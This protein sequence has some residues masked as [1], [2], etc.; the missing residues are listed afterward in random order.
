MTVVA[1]IPARLASTRL[2]CK[3]LVDISGKPMIQ[4]VYE[5]AIRARSVS[6]VIVATDDERIV[7]VVQGFGGNVVMT[8]KAHVSGTD[9]VAEAAGK[10]SAEIIV[11]LQGDEPMIEPEMIDAAV[12]PMLGDASIAICTLKTSISTRAEFLNPNVVKVVTDRSGFA[13]YFSRSPIP[14]HASN[15]G[16]ALAYKHIGLYVYRKDFLLKFTALKPAPLEM[17]ERLEQLRAIE[18]GFRIKVV[19]TDKNPL[20]VDTPED[21]EA[22]RRMFSA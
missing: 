14:C 12:E 2:A 11:N 1:F 5:R 18:N 8:S 6:A 20:S 17:I 19:E 21:L 4:R 7:D 10:A 16:G 22:V 3:P 15:N 13:L 9:R